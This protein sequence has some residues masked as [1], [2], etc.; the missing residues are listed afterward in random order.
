MSVTLTWTIYCISNILNHLLAP[1]WAHNPWRGVN[2]TNLLGR[3]AD[4]ETLEA[5][6][7]VNSESTA[8]FILLQNKHD[9]QVP[10]KLQHNGFKRVRQSKTVYPIYSITAQ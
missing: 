6:A 2:P 10:T 7:A 9:N 5:G 4:P 1:I 8:K 3:T